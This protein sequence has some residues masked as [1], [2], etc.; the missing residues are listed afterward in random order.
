MIIFWPM[1]KSRRQVR[2]ERR[3][4]QK[5]KSWISVMEAFV[6]W[7]ERMQERERIKQVRRQSVPVT[8]PEM[9]PVPEPEFTEELNDN[10]IAEMIGEADT[11]I[12]LG[13]QSIPAV[14]AYLS[15]KTGLPKSLVH[16]I[17][18][19]AEATNLKAQGEKQK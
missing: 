3:R 2:K 11:L 13:G 14:A 17:L 9:V 18:L 10:D 15:R 4:K 7:T 8:L 6:A 1:G 16:D 12:H 19:D 5:I